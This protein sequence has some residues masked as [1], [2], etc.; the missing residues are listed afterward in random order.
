MKLLVTARES[1]NILEESDTLLR[2][3]YKV[4]DGNF[5]N[6]YPRTTSIKP[7]FEELHVDVSNK[8]QV[9]KALNDIRDTLKDSQKIQLTV[10]FVPNE[11]FL[12]KLKI[13]TEQNVGT[14]VIL[15]IRIDSGILGGVKLVF[16]GLYKDFSLIAK[17]SNYFK[18]YNNVSQL[19][20]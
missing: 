19:P 10:A 1:E 8:Q 3:L 7:L 5:D 4:E 16:N 14:N 20:R 11:K 2:S 12:D 9:E 18:E 15:D 6:E 13:W 17:L